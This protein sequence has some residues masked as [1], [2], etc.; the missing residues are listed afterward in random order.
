VLYATAW[1][2]LTAQPIVLHIPQVTDRYFLLE[3]LDAWTNVD[4][5]P[6]TQEA[7]PEGNYLIAGPNWQGTPPPGITQVFAMPTNTAWIAGRTYTNRRPEDVIKADVIQRQYTL[8]PLSSFTSGQPY[9]PPTDLPVNPA[10][11]ESTPPVNQVANMSAG[12]F[13]GTLAAMMGTMGTSVPLTNPPLLPAD[14]AAEE[15]LKKIG[16]TPGD[17]F[18]ISTLP[19]R[20]A[21]TLELAARTAQRIVSSDATLIAIGGRPVNGWTWSTDLGQYGTNYLARAVVANRGIGANLSSD[22]VYFYAQQDSRGVPLNGDKRYTLTFPAG[23]LPPV[24]PSAFWSVTMYNAA[25]FLVSD[26]NNNLGSTQIN[27]GLPPNP[28]M[29]GSYRFFIQAN[30]PTNPAQVPYWIRAPKGRQKFLLLLRTY[31]PSDAILDRQY[32][33]PPVVRTGVR[34]TPL[35]RA[36]RLRLRTPFIP[37][38]LGNLVVPN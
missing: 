1:L 14:A 21:A 10:I 16:L 12:T 23:Q 35:T 8:T 6:G 5:H 20:R 36:A 25:G 26:L 37:R 13:F 9:T 27:A 4:Y 7:T 34:P 2:N 3:I 17:A 30:R 19:R 24:N 32:Q 29:G 18:D 31:W 38:R 28:N 15:N 33:P 22:A 11:D